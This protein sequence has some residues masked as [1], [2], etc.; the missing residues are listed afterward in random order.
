MVRC[1]RS[2]AAVI[3][4]LRWDVGRQLVSGPARRREVGSHGTM[5]VPWA[6][7]SFEEPTA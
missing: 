3:F 5:F 6:L 4:G 2:L 1:N 7:V